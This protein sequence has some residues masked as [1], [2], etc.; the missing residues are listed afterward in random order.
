MTGRECGECGQCCKLIGVRELEKAPHVWCRYYKRGK[1]CGVYEDRPRGCAD[2]A[3]DWLLDTRL[4]QAW[5]PDR[6]G[7]VLHAGDGGRT[8][9]VEL[10]PTQPSAWRR[11]PF[12]VILRG[13]ANAGAAE[14]LEVLIWVGRR[15]WRL[16][17]GGGEIDLGVVRPAV[18]FASH[19]RL[20]RP[21]SG[22]DWPPRET[23][24]RVEPT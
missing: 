19:S 16:T 17:P 8:I 5:R 15:C 2:F 23:V 22:R 21:G 14:G 11:A 3:C 7:F 1:G 6:S 12:E 20:R 13:W 4:D 9:N 18:G 24:G 10:D